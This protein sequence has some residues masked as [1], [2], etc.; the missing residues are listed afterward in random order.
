MTDVVSV[1]ILVADA[2]GKPIDRI[3]E[4]DRLALFERMELHIGGCAANTG[5]ALSKLGAKVKVVGK[6]GADGFGDFIV[7]TLRKKNVD[8]DGV[9]RDSSVST[10]FTFVMITSAGK[11]RFLHCMGASAAFSLNDID[12]S[13]LDDAR[14]L[15]VAGTYLMPTFDGE[16]TAELLKQ[17]QKRG[18]ITSMDTAFNDQVKDWSEIAD[19]CLPYLDYFLPSFEE[20]E[21]ITGESDPQV[22]ARRLKELC[23]GMVGI[24]LGAE[25]FYL[26][27]DEVERWISPYSVKVV[28]TSG[29]GDS[30]VAGFLRGILEGWDAERCARF[31]SAT[32]AFCIGAIGCTAGLRSMQET[33]DFM[34]RAR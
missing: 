4:E 32:A 30:F 31:G 33:L 10:S 17:A 12:L 5:I 6:V 2:L 13:V 19:L 18:V 16:Q 1:G 29:A 20:A 21:K 9:V 3:P 34:E 8:A 25:G 14:I 7:K 23:P 28:D 22:I 24:K 15:H 11:R 27:T 26:K